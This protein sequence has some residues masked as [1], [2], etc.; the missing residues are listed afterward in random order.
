VLSEVA[1]GI[2]ITIASDGL[3]IA[4]LVPIASVSPSLDELVWAGR[5]IG[6][7]SGGPLT[8]PPTCGAESVDVAAALAADRTAERW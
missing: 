1:P 2:A 8:V 5:A 7:S 4:R 6:P 3:P